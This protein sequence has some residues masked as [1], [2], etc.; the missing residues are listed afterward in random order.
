MI[1][2][3]ETMSPQAPTRSGET[4]LRSDI[5][6][7]RALAVVS[8]LLYHF[9][10]LRLPGGFVGV[11]VFFVISG[12]LITGQLLRG[13][14]QH[15]RVRL[16]EFWK[17]RAVRL[18]PSSLLVLVATSIATLAWVPLDRWQQFFSE[19]AASTLYVENWQLSRSATDYL[20]AA[21][22]PSAVQHFW[23]LSVEEQFYIVVPLL[24]AAALLLRSRWRVAVGV[25]LVV[26]TLASFA[27]SV[28]ATTTDPSAAYFVT[29]TRA[30]EFGV[31]ALLAYVALEAPPRLRTFAAGAGLTAIVASA[32][33]VSGDTPFPGWIAAVPVLATVVV[34]WAHVSAGPLAVLNG[35]RPVQFL[36][37]VSYALYLWHWPLVV[38]PP[39]ALERPLTWPVKL[40]LVGLAVVLAAVTTTRF[41]EPIR[42]GLVRRPGG[43]RLVLG[44]IAVVMV[45]LLVTALLAHRSVDRRTEELRAGALDQ[46]GRCFG[47]MA[48][49]DPGCPAPERLVP[50]ADLIA[51]DEPD[52]PECLTVDGSAALSLCELGPSDGARSM[53]AIG[54][55]HLWALLPALDAAADELGWHIDVMAHT[56]CYWSSAARIRPTDTLEEE[57]AGWNV[58]VEDHLEEAAPYDAIIVTHKE[59]LLVETAAGQSQADAAAAGLLDAWTPQLERGVPII[60]L[61]DVPAFP[62][63]TRDCVA[64]H[65]LDG[66]RACDVPAERAFPDTLS[67]DVAAEAASG[68][69]EVVDLGRDIYCPGRRC[70]PVVGGVVMQ[71]DEG[72]LTNSYSS[73][74]APYL[75]RVLKRA[76]R[77]VA[78]S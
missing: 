5:Q 75:T 47:A 37:H 10:P 27:Y 25:M 59:S 76:W 46:V 56:G 65:G 61:T 54:D 52:Y 35:W 53:A 45:A 34:I 50:P 31:G 38:L 29:T 69:V 30:W 23:S 42:F 43:R 19:I 13:V 48:A 51:E 16:L 3:S 2:A 11:D 77:S 74:L 60:S 72:H 57:C 15:G 73:S 12:Y 26:L 33:L 70:A 40:L 22:E 7:L 9:W 78:P 39:I 18:L 6:A 64:E 21:N 41:E 71:F 55:S 28:H 62:K 68:R 24:I 67:A 36:G 4:P 14:S 1:S 32:F 17:R 58:E 66:A 20:A 44:G 49:L 8:V 63:D